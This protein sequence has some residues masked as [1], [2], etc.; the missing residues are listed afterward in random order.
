MPDRGMK[1][2]VF[3]AS[4]EHL[5]EQYPQTARLLGTEIGKRG[6]HLIYG[7]TNQGLMREVAEATLAG[8]GEVT[9]IIP[10]CIRRKGVAAGGDVRLIVAADMK[11]RKQLLREHADA[12]IALPGGWGTLEEITEVITLKQL[13]EH[14]KPIIFLN[15]G[16][17]YNTFFHFI[18]ECREKG[19]VSGNYEGMYQVTTEVDE[20]IDYV[21]KGQSEREY[22]KY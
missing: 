14:R 18:G 5:E 9:G 2:A 3:C 22:S 6:W 12:F 1:I 8:G 16:G 11:E 15:T 20:A 4:A 10:E 7:G 13:G 17:F 19:F 21:L